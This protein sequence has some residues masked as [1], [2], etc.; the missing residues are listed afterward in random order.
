METGSPPAISRTQAVLEVAAAALI[1]LIAGGLALSMPWLIT[2][3]GF[4]PIQDFIQLSSAFFPRLTFGVL[5]VLG[6]IY[7][8]RAALV[9]RASPGAGFVWWDPRYRNVVLLVVLASLYFYSMP[10]LGFSVA[11]GL[12]TLALAVLVGGGRWWLVACLALI[13]PVT[14]RFVFE[15][16]LLI[17]LPRSEFDAI[18]VPE[19]ALMQWL[20]RTLT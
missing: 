15:R 6:A 1:I 12:S 8:G 4:N 11:T 5:A 19:E 13:A 2:E 3:S 9:L 14:I 16:L 18:A 7:L 20:V 17:S 10:W